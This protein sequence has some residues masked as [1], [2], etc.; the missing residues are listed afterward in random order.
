MLF[1]YKIPQY[2]EIFCQRLE[3]GACII[4]E[5]LR[6]ILLDRD[7]ASNNCFLTLTCC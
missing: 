3:K 4:S 1:V 5:R 6:F 7:S 2:T